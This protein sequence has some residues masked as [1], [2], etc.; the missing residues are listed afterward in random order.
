MAIPVPRRIAVIENTCR[1]LGSTG[2]M[3]ASDR[4]EGT[5]RGWITR[6]LSAYFEVSC[7]SMQWMRG[8]S[9][10]SVTPSPKCFSEGGVSTTFD[11][12]EAM[13][14]TGGGRFWTPTTPPKLTVGQRPLGGGKGN[15]KGGSGR[16]KWG[17]GL[18][19][20]GGGASGKVG[21]GGGGPGG[22][23]WGVGG[24][25]GA[26]APLTSDHQAF[27]AKQYRCP[28]PTCSG[29]GHCSQSFPTPGSGRPAV[30]TWILLRG[31]RSSGA[32]TVDL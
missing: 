4:A 22:A 5:E 29:S 28:A 3:S 19:G 30:V 1:G 31:A 14:S 23:I 10:H 20:A 6:N 8:Q 2:S 24:G 18:G 21:W 26:Q 9:C 15:W 25:G 7:N 27:P 17:G 11:E 16:G 32:I 12:R 13:H